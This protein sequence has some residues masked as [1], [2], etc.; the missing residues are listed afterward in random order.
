[1]RRDDDDDDDD[2]DEE[3]GG[4]KQPPWWHSPCRRRRRR[5]A[6]CRRHLPSSVSPSYA[7]VVSQDQDFSL[8]AKDSP[9]AEIVVSLKRLQSQLHSLLNRGKFII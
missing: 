1:M 3:V 5:R 4:T 2:D 6:W 8:R 7:F 9:L